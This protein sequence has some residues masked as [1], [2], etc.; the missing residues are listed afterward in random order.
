MADG[1][2]SAWCIYTPNA[3]FGN[4][5]ISE[6]YYPILY[7]GRNIE[8][9]S[10]GYGMYRGGL[11][12][13]AIWMFKNTPGMEYQCGCAGIR[14]KVVANHG[15]FGA[16]PTWPD[17]AG[18]AIETNVKELIDARK[19]LVHERGDPDDPQLTANVKA[20]VLENNA[21]PPFVAPEQLHDYDI[22]IHPVSGSQALG[23]PFERDPALV[24]EDLTKGWTREWVAKDIYGVVAKQDAKTKEYAADEAATKK[25][26]DEM[27]AARKARGVPFREWWAKERARLE[28]HEELHPAVQEMWRSSTTLTPG[29]G[30]QIREFWQL[31]EDYS[32]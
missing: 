6:S 23:D 8:P 2:N 27:R 19:P 31:P 20:R 24:C 21:V 29:Y 14:G 3:D 12:H 32:F 7:L 10:G 1:E 25:L 4:A 22:V 16:Y 18:Y 30:A 26:R 9:D 15:M 13:T 5:E 17:R 28:A 11:G